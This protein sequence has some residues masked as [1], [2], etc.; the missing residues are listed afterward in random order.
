MLI[1]RILAIALTAV[2]AFVLLWADTLY[3]MSA[4]DASLVAESKRALLVGAATLI[5]GAFLSYR[6]ARSRAANRTAVRF[7]SSLALGVALGWLCFAV[8]VYDMQDTLVFNPSTL[9]EARLQTIATEY[10]QAETVEIVARDGAVLRGWLLPPQQADHATG[11]TAEG[12]TPLVILFT[13]QGGEASRY[14][15]MA[16]QVPEAAW[17]FINYRGY[18]ASDGTPSDQA[19]FDD[20]TVI[21][22]YFTARPDI[23]SEHVF[24][25]AG[26][27][28]TGV[29]TYL[30]SQRPLA[31]VV[32]FSPYDSIGA[33]VLQDLMPWLPTGRIFR[34]RFDAAD[35]APNVQAPLL[36]IV[37]TD[38]KVIFP[39][40]S[41]EL[42]RRW[43]GDKEL[44]VIPGG[45]HFNIYNEDVAW[46][47]V[48]RFVRSQLHS[49]GN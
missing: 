37:G 29:A 47:A 41:E 30:A 22:D 36:A 10:P 21:Y 32:L 33:G 4:L 17:A 2:A 34:N 26:S 49:A 28:G 9:S 27:M 19:F 39:A 24:A 45:D 42:V 11:A 14:F 40:R 6:F 38:D 13:G 7:I 18:G 8:V 48:Q 12:K 46:Q 35:Y 25:L 16:T 44:L 43:G 20:A 5:V 15:I 1:T 23:D 31:G 3:R